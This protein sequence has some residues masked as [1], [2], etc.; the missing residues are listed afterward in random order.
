MKKKMAFVDLTNY[1]DWPMG[2]MIQYELNILPYLCE[3]YNVDLWGVTVNGKVNNKL[4]INSKE[5]PIHSWTN[6]KTGFRLIPNY[7]K[8]LLLYRY[9]SY[10]KSYDIVYVHTGSCISPLLNLGNELVV[11]HQH[12]LMY[13]SD[14]SLKTKLEK[15][16]MKKAQHKSN[17]LFVVSGEK[18]TAQFKEE[19]NLKNRVVAINSP[20]NF[21]TSNYESLKAKFHRNVPHNYIYTGRLTKFK[22]VEFLIESFKIYINKY[23]DKAKLTIIGDG[24][25]YET[26]KSVILKE[27]LQN[28]IFLKGKLPHYLI[29]DYLSKNDIFLMPSKGEG[30]SVSVAEANSYG[31][32]TV[33]MKVIG[34]DEQVRENING[35]KS[36]GDSPF[37]FAKT[38]Y[39][40]SSNWHSLVSSTFNYSK[41][42][43]SKNIA[44]KIISNIDNAVNSFNLEE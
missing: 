18:T 32:P 40:V 2:G 16:L 25:E 9:R 21:S 30:V 37:S 26:L 20:V 4:I 14:N 13:K 11:Y 24:E 15:P 35:K 38:I 10:F 7:W 36:Q 27:R 43:D 42:Y 22:N 39:D 6:C 8:G 1:K 33:C 31:L 44:Q 28:S 3:H 17:L 23:D 34:L 29:K 12:G 19:E 5:Y 41:Q